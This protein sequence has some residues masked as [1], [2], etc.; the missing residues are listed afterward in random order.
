MSVNAIET[1]AAAADAI[2]RCKITPLTSTDYSEHEVK[3]FKRSLV[4]AAMS[5]PSNHDGGNH[6]LAGI[7]DS[8]EGYR[9]LLGKATAVFTPTP[10]PNENGPSIGDDDKPAQVA[11]ATA[12]YNDECTKYY[13]EQGCMKGL[14]D[15]I[16]KNVPAEALTAL[17]DE[18]YGMANVTA[19]VM[20]AHLESNCSPTDCIEVEELLELR[21]AAIDFDGEDTSVKVHYT[22]LERLVKML[23]THGVK[24]SMSE[25]IVRH[26]SQFKQHG[27][28][29]DEVTE[30]E[31]KNQSE[32]T[33]DNFKKHFTDA[34]HARRQRNK[35]TNKTAGSNGYGS[36]NN[37]VDMDELKD[38]INRTLTLGLSGITE[39]AE[40]TINAVVAQKF[41]SLPK[42][43]SSGTNEAV[44][45]A[46][47][48]KEM[49]SLRL[50][51]KEV[52]EENKKL[53]KKKGGRGRYDKP[54]KHCENVHRHI[55]EDR[56]WGNPKNKDKAP[57]GWT[58]RK[59]E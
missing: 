1:M 43:T 48:E 21:D 39:A 4:H 46:S 11:K 51:L 28:F 18:T 55:P 6:G 32:R 13:T 17:E 41:S 12:K 15:A 36:A 2:G 10:K 33:W 9:A 50:K 14:K 54:C 19:K 29:K 31:M 3:L 22:K 52:E 20:L 27:D 44:W 8:Q 5:I 49:E 7:I 58:P 38:E 34:D 23:Q 24:T 40:E 59:K 47:F 30:W 53:K 26:L 42:D 16:V 56:C 57:E 45:K 37:V 25:I 35:Y